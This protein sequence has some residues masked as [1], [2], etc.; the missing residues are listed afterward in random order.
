V[1]LDREKLGHTRRTP[2]TLLLR[3]TDVDIST[4]EEFAAFIRS[5]AARWEKM[6]KEAGIRYD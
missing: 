1:V 6:L 2:C 5:E 4:P 3:R